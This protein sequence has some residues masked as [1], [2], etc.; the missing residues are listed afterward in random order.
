ML[1]KHFELILER[2]DDLHFK[3]TTPMFPKCKGFGFNKEEAIDKLCNSISSFIAR[4]SKKFLKNI[5]QHQNY[6]ELIT[7]PSKKESFQHR[8]INLNKSTK[9]SEQVFFKLLSV[10]DLMKDGSGYSSTEVKRAFPG[11]LNKYDGGAD[12]IIR[13]HLCMN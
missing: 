1:E 10:E 6:S 13:V 3:A 8:I 7:D 9:Y 11:F 4:S 5:L 12:H 2:V